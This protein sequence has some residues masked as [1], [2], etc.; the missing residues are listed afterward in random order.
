MTKGF[1]I[2]IA[3]DG[4]EQALNVVRYVG[5]TF[6]AARTA[7]VLFHVR[8]GLSESF[9]DLRKEA[10]CRPAV[11]KAKAWDYQ[12]Q[13]D[14]DAFISNANCILSAAGFPSS[15]ITVNIQGKKVGIARDI[16]SE[17]LKG[18]DATVVGRTGVNKVKDFF[19]GSVANKLVGKM[20]HIPIVVVVGN[21]EPKKVLVGFDG[22]E[23][24]RRAVSSVAAL[25]DRTNCCVTLCY[26]V[27]QLTIPL[28]GEMV[29]TPYNESEL[30]DETKKEMSPLI[31]DAKK[32]LV[33]VGFESD[34]VFVE[35]LD[36]EINRAYRLIKD[37]KDGGYG[38]IVVG[39]RG[40]GVVEEFV[41]GRVS[42]KVL[43]MAENM[44][45]WVV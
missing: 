22:S 45:V 23:G 12:T 16:L 34:N 21:P 27:Q 32:Q 1:K 39:R 26:V 40:L 11:M 4:S 2:L 24:A 5:G 30:L 43:N 10:K 36:E 3:V 28:G 18:Y 38:S 41:F 37:A 15:A 20:P 29:F 9:V 8:E 6:P 25:L 7:V 13:K 14:L 17:S 35:L 31:Q 44:A 42:A 19:F 33:D